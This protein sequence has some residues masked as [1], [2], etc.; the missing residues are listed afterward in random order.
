MNYPRLGYQIQDKE[1]LGGPVRYCK[2][3]DTKYLKFKLIHKI[4]NIQ[5]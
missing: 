1:F 5:K 4:N 2:Y 3:S